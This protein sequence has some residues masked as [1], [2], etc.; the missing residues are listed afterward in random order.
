MDLVIEPIDRTSGLA[1]W[2]KS[3][4]YASLFVKHCGIFGRVSRNL[5]EHFLSA[6]RKVHILIQIAEPT[7]TGSVRFGADMVGCR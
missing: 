1:N 3:L 6:I 7:V 5:R 2:A 4:A